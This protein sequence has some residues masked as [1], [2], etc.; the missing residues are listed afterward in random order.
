M[1]YHDKYERWV[2]P[3]REDFVLSKPAIQDSE[4]PGFF[5]TGDPLGTQPLAELR[6]YRPIDMP[7]LTQDCFSTDSLIRLRSF[8]LK[9]ALLSPFFG[10]VYTMLDST[11]NESDVFLKKGQTIPYKVL[12]KCVKLIVPT[13]TPKRM[14]EQQ[15]DVNSFQVIADALHL[16]K[17][18]RLIVSD[19]GVFFCSVNGLK[20][21]RNHK[22]FFSKIFVSYTELLFNRQDGLGYP[23]VAAQGYG[24]SLALLALMGNEWT[25]L[26]KYI[27]DYFTAYPSLLLEG[28]SSNEA[29]DLAL[30]TYLN[31]N[32][33][34]L[35]N[36]FGLI[37]MKE[38]E[39]GGFVE[40]V[41]KSPIFERIF[42]VDPP[43]QAMDNSNSLF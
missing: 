41:R 27:S 34:R 23:G 19:K 16:L 4:P 6:G 28:G 22:D 32:F 38:P 36:D 37:E 30:T 40:L 5:V 12:L 10:L 14:K 1:D 8:H 21:L 13:M 31:R 15:I 17:A 18:N 35:F 39:E 7:L 42:E 3:G 29:V 43:Q 26:T 25:L 24:Y 33:Y 2:P 11:R 20:A 9:T